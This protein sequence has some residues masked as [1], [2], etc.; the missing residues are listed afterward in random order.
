MTRI[1]VGVLP[2][3]LCD[4]HLLA[5]IRELPRCF[6]YDAMRAPIEFTLGKGHVLWC[7]RFRGSLYARLHNLWIEARWRGFKIVECQPRGIKALWTP[8]SFKFWASSDEAYARDII[9]DRIMTRMTS[10]VRKP[11]WTNRQPPSWFAE[12]Q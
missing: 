4:Q 3:E 1:N 9:I 6:A 8:D 12:A 5:E 2:S 10:M 7:A 11:R